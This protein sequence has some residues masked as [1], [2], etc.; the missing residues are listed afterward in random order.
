MRTWSGLLILGLAGCG[1]VRPADRASF[2]EVPAGLCRVGADGAMPLAERG[3]G[4]TGAPA[5][6]RLA[7]RGIGGTGAPAAPDGRTGIVGVITGF[8]SV[9]LAGQEVGYPPDLPVLVDGRAAGLDV[10]RA[11]QVAVVVADGAAPVAAS[12][13][14][15]HEVSGPVDR[16]E[17][18]G[19]LRVAGQRVLPPPGTVS[20]LA[21]S[22]EW[23]LVSGVRRADGA[24]VA[25]RLDPRGS[26][27]VLIRG[28]LREDAGRLWIGLAEIRPGPGQ[29]RRPGLPVVAVGRWNAGVLEA[30]TVEID[31][32][33]QDPVQF[34]GPVVGTLVLEGYA[35]G[36]VFSFGRGLR[37]DAPPGS[38]R[39]LARLERGAGGRFAPAF[40]RPGGPGAGLDGGPAPRGGGFEP[41]PIPNRAMERGFRGEGPGRAG[42]GQPGAGRRG[43]GPGGE[44]AM[45]R[46]NG[47][48][49]GE[50]APSPGGGFRG[51]GR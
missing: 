6:A 51:P 45:G 1:P 24:V 40:V 33:L 23:V 7:D 42:P 4:G 39:A 18:D 38:F 41:A 30:D 36:G 35:E 17:A 2:P 48:P 28:P 15:R 13:S 46:R 10:L 21:R 26:G 31:G 14:V 49:A 11:G 44:P 32:L 43:G 5:A 20:P 50:G 27:E 34:F 22:G 29:V 8:A 19:S 12:L 25:T 3:I 9:C 47:D 16:V 37:V